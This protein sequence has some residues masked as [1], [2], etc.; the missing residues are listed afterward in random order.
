MELER[1]RGKREEDIEI[2]EQE[3]ED[4][5][6][7][8]DVEF[9]PGMDVLCGPN[10]REGVIVRKE[11]DGRFQV[12]VGQMR[13]TFKESDL[14]PARKRNVKTQA[15]YDSSAIKSVMPKSS[16]DVRGMRLEESLEAIDNQIEACC[17]HGLAGFSIIHGYGNGILSTGIQDRKSVV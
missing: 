5:E 3:L 9:V 13:F 1:Q 8:S 14:S 17:V 12:A 16:L 6:E 15:I 2:T 7:P 4:Y 10:K 11:K